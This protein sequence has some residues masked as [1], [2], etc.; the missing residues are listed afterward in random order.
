MQLC[1]RRLQATV[2]APALSRRACRPERLP[3]RPS[4]FP[5][6]PLALPLHFP[7]QCCF[8]RLK[9]LPCK[10]TTAGHR[11]SF[12]DTSARRPHPIKDAQEHPVPPPLPNPRSFLCFR[13]S[14]SSPL[15]TSGH[16][17]L[18]PAADPNHATLSPSD[19]TVMISRPP[20]SLSPTA[21]EPT[22]LEPP[23]SVSFGE[24]SHRHWLESMVDSWTDTITMVHRTVSLAHKVFYSKTYIF[25]VNPE[26]FTSKPS[27]FYKFHSS[28]QFRIVFRI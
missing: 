8:P 11:Y 7:S 5:T 2:V 1:R 20:S 27:S 22:W 18:L 23:G 26:K 21:G 25:P 19:A 9:L 14:S 28:P 10:R 16:R 6:K 17:R 24:L 13:T 15:R 4:I 3:I 12:P